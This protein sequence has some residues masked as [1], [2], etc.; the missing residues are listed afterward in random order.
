MSDLS[1]RRAVHA[2]VPAIAALLAD[3]FIAA[4]REGA[5]LADYEAGFAAVAADPNQLLAVAESNGAVVGTMQISFIPGL[6]RGGRW[7]GHV[8]AVRV[9]SDRRGQ[10]IGEAMMAWAQDRCRER[11]C[12]VCELTSDKRRDGAHRFYARLGFQPTHLGYKK[13]LG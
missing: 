3:D 6:S 8:E 5:P 13:M 9:A 2:D 4:A 7:R 10:K 1:I 12:V 11:G